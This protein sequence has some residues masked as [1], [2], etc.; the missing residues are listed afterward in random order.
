[1]IDD[2]MVDVDI[3][4]AEARGRVKALEDVLRL[5]GQHGKPPE[6]AQVLKIEDGG[7]DLPINGYGKEKQERQP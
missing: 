1:M 5:I 4:L 3:L 7:G 6:A 2:V